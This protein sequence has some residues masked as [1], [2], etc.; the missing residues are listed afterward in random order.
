MH[1]TG[2][3]ASSSDDDSSS[4]DIDFE[5]AARYARMIK[6]QL[7]MDDFLR[8]RVQYSYLR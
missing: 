8:V 4:A 3:D 1:C 6:D 7:E 5:E 2:S